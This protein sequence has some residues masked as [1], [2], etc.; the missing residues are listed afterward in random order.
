MKFELWSGEGWWQS[1][2]SG[3][4]FSGEFALLLLRR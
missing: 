1:A 2:F 3:P 4:G